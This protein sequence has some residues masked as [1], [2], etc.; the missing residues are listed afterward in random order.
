MDGPRAAH[1][2]LFGWLHGSGSGVFAEPW[3][4]DAGAARAEAMRKR[5]GRR[6]IFGE[7]SESGARFLSWSAVA[8]GP[9]IGQAANAG[10]R[11]HARIRSEGRL[12]GGAERVRTG[13][14]IRAG[15]EP[16]RRR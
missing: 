10:I 5:N 2:D 8:S 11:L 9:Q 14:I 15:R 12:A 16:R 1:G 6:E 3:N 7:A 4:Q 13:A